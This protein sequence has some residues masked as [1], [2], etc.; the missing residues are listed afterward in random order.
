MSQTNCKI[1][2]K[3][4]YMSEIETRAP[5][6]TFLYFFIATCALA[7]VGAK[8]PSLAQDVGEIMQE[9]LAGKTILVFAKVT[10]FISLLCAIR[11]ILK[12]GP[13]GAALRYL[14]VNPSNFIV[15][16]AFVA[17]AINWAVALSSYILFPLVARGEIF[18]LAVNNALEIS[19]IAVVLAVSAWALHYSPAVSKTAQPFSDAGKTTFWLVFGM[20][21]LFWLVVFIRLLMN[22]FVG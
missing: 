14:V 3:L 4:L 16:L 5:L 15:S 20:S 7:V 17:A 22:A 8:A 21:M 10:L 11:T 18:W 9:H 19:G 13:Y 12:P 6:G 2:V 1:Y